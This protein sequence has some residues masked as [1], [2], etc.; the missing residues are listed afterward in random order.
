MP[1]PTRVRRNKTA[2]ELAETFNVT[3]KTIRNHFAESR[4]DYEARAVLRRQQIIDLRRQGLTCKA[5][6]ENLQVSRPLVVARLKEA[7]TQGVELNES[8]SN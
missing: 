7:R 8:K 6:A 2:R 1:T 3:P 4:E 5:I